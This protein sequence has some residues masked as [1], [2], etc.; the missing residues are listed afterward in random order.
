MKTKLVCISS[1]LAILMTSCGGSNSTTASKATTT[2]ITGVFADAPVVGMSYACGSETGTTAAGGTFTCPTGSTVNFSVGAITVCSAPVQAYMTPVSC[3]Q[4][5]GDSSA[6]ASTS[7][8]V[9]VAQF[10]ITIGTPTGTTPGSLSTL[11]ITS[12]ELKAASAVSLDFATA[13]L[14]ELQTAV[15]TINPGQTLASAS[16]A[17]NELTGTV[18]T[19]VAGTYSGTYS[20]NDTGTWTMTIDS[21]GNVSGS[22]A[23]TVGGGGSGILSGALAN[24]TTFSGQYSDGSTSVAGSWS[25]IV[26]TAQSPTTGKGSYLFSGTWDSH[27]GGG[28]GIFTN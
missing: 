16:T 18:N 3:A 15:N 7:S 6:D 1:V 12:A 2:N 8:V 26:N 28:D 24:G 9:A 10:L 4:A 5:N 25:G 17:Q 13:T 20:G 22:W 11:T 14:A 23:S 19:N 27:L 21:S